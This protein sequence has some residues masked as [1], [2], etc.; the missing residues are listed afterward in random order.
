MAVGRVA[1]HYRSEKNPPPD[2]NYI[3]R[4]CSTEVWCETNEDC[5]VYDD[6]IRKSLD[7]DP[8]YVGCGVDIFEYHTCWTWAIIYT[9]FSTYIPYTKDVLLAEELIEIVYTKLYTSSTT[10][11]ACK[12][13][14]LTGSLFN[15]QCFAR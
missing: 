2:R 11:A 5:N 12:N 4:Y 1:P 13:T 14:S 10:C 3:W 9:K 7:H 8:G 15:S 6:C